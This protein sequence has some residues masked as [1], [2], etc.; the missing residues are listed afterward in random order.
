MGYVR[1]APVKV[2]L[3]RLRGWEITAIEAGFIMGMYAAL[4]EIEP[5]ERHHLHEKIQSR[6]RLPLEP[7]DYEKRVA[8]LLQRDKLKH[9]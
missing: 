2:L 6:I 7:F 4:R 3:D 8:H 9:G 1:L 5:L